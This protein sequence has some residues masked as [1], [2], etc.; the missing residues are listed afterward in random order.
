MSDVVGSRLG[1]EGVGFID[2][3]MSAGAVAEM[4]GK[5]LAVPLDESIERFVFIGMLGR[6]ANHM[7]QPNKIISIT[8]LFAD[9]VQINQGVGSSGRV[10]GILPQYRR[11]E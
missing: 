2:T 1:I 10:T 11:S 5:W 7:V 9:D 8:P 6:S 3:D 4:V